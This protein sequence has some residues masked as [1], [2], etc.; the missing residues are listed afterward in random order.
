VDYLKFK[1]GLHYGVVHY[2][3]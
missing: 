1:T 2:C 3:L